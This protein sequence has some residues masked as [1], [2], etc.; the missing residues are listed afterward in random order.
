M[1]NEVQF[2]VGDYVL[3][4]DEDHR[5]ADEIGEIIALDESKRQACWIVRWPALRRVRRART[6][7]YRVD[8]ANELLRLA[9]KVSAVSIDATEWYCIDA[10]HQALIKEVRSVYMYEP[11]V[12]VHLCEAT[13][14]YALHYLYTYLVLAEGAEDES[15]ELDAQY[16]YE[17]LEPVEY[18]H[19]SDVR[20]MK[21]PAPIECGAYATL[22]E[23]SEN[24]RGNCPF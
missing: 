10:E 1:R 15:G 9:V 17:S 13:P 18:R 2:K 4:T 12:G 24:L 20:A 21:H 7:R 23:A 8:K 22:D 16:C 6:R 5:C 19:C 14:S 11:D 3:R